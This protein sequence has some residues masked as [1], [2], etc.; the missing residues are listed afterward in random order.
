MTN[1]LSPVLG[2]IVF[3]LVLDDKPL[4]GEVVSLALPPPPK[5]DLQAGDSSIDKHHR[6]WFNRAKT[7]KG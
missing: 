1:D 2:C 6:T 5:L 7:I 3:I 4:A